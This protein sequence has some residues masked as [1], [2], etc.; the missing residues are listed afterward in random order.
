MKYFFIIIMTQ[1]LEM[2]ALKIF[3]KFLDEEQLEF[4]LDF[5]RLIKEFIFFVYLFLIEMKSKMICV[6]NFVTLNHY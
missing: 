6:V 3:I 2:F 5:F 1:Y 4:L